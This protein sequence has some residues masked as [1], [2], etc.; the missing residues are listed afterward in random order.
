M[1]G[2][3][4]GGRA[5]A[6]ESLHACAERAERPSA[7]AVYMAA[8]RAE[9]LKG[10]RAAPRKIALVAPLPFC[11]M[12]MAAAGVFGGGAIG[13]FATYGWNYWYAL[14]LPVAVA[15][16]TASI[17]NIDA[18]QKLRPVLGLP[19][20]PSSAWWAKVAYALVLALAANLVVLTAGVAADL[21]GCDAPSAAAGLV[22]AVLLVVGNAW[23]VPVGLA[24]TTRFGTLA[25]IAVPVMLQ[26]GM[27]IAFWTSP[28]WFLFPPATTLCAAS[29]FMGVAPSGV[30]L[31]AGDPLGSFGWEAMLGLGIAV[32]VFVVLAALGARWYGRREAK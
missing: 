15:L 10:K 13:A 18:R 22:T 23:M 21:L 9:A 6:A 11:A 1:T 31:E 4:A 25:G 28:A 16:V 12:G 26:L 27:G 2:R 8:F 3:R 17:A 24:L 14:M 29:P 20:P 7:F 5:E 30:P 32:A 19:L